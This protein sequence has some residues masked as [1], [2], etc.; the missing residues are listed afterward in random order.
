MRLLPVVVLPD[1]ECAVPLGRA[2]IAADLP[3]IEIT[4][5]TEA[6]IPA[7]REL[8]E[9]CPQLLLAAGTVTSATLAREAIASGAQLLVAPNLDETVLAVA[10]E[11]DVPLL[12]GVL[13]PTEVARARSLGLNMVK[14]F[15]ASAVGGA[16]YARSLASVFPDLQLVPTGGVDIENLRDYLSVENVAACGGSWLA[17]LHLLRARRFDE[18]QLR[19]A[20]ALA[21][22]RTKSKERK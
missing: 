11:H 13:T 8:R 20:E 21:V 5:R 18:I 17:P 7:L 12:P 3:I 16:S 22:A 15:P 2:L 1:V 14:L 19:I 4:C 9:H 6:A 10:G